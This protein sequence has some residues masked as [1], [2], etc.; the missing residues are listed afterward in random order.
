VD[1]ILKEEGIT[2]PV[3][4]MHT[5]LGESIRKESESSISVSELREQGTVA[6]LWHG[7]YIHNE[8][9]LAGTVAAPP[10]FDSYHSYAD[11]LTFLD[12]LVTQFPKNAR[13]VSAGRS[14]EGRDIKGIHIFG[15]RGPG[16]NPAIIWHG[17]VHAREW[18]ATMVCILTTFSDF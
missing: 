7:L 13:I 15:S 6:S 4:T 3:V 1:G 10:W 16:H 11:H 9:F 5:D 18:I 14:F 2:T 8:S 12:D 17:T